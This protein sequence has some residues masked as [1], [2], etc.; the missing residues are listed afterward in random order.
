MYAFYS[1]SVSS[2]HQAKPRLL[3]QIHKQARWACYDTDGSAPV[4]VV[5]MQVVVASVHSSSPSSVQHGAPSAPHA[6]D[7]TEPGEPRCFCVQASAMRKSKRWCLAAPTGVPSWSSTCSQSLIVRDTFAN[8]TAMPLQWATRTVMSLMAWLVTRLE[9]DTPIG[10]STA[11][12]VPALHSV[13]SCV[14]VSAPASSTQH[15]SVSKPHAAQ[16]SPSQRTQWST[17]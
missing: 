6:A 8:Y 3:G 7:T 4:Q 16:G 2:P 15:G 1:Y 5:P 12:Q 11:T 17:H 14:Q 10:G 13:S 9:G